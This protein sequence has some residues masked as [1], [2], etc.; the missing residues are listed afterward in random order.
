MFL[1]INEIGPDGI[2]FQHRLEIDGLEGRA[3]ERIAVAEAEIRG[4][5][6]KGTRGIDFSAR[7][8]GR[9][10]L[11]CSRC[12]E[13]VELRVATRFDLVLVPDA[14]EFVG[15]GDEP[16]DAAAAKLFYTTEGKAS[17]TDIAVE[18]FYLNLPQKPVCRADCRGLCP[19]CGANRNETACGCEP[20][21]LDPRLAPLLALRKKQ[22]DA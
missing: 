19:A 12:L 10:G 11:E 22:G 9:L 13:Q 4:A 6:R 15:G 21:D 2:T 7:L 20:D 1:N 5:A 18:Q 8:E 16:F 17:L 14:V 3:G